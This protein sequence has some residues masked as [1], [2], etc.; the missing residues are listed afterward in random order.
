MEQGDDEVPVVMG[1]VAALHLKVL[2]EVHGTQKALVKV[3]TASGLQHSIKKTLE[4]Y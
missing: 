3:T 4:T 1:E 2:V